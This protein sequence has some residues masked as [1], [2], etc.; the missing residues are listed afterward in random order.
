MRRMEERLETRT[1]LGRAGERDE[2]E[3]EPGKSEERGIP[4]AEG[5]LVV[6]SGVFIRRRKPPTRDAAVGPSGTLRDKLE[7]R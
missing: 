1:G 4:G 2:T 7:V 3:R 5:R 6:W